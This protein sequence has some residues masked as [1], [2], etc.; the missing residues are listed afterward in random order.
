MIHLLIQLKGYVE[1]D[2][3]KRLLLQII[4]PMTEDLDQDLQEAVLI[5]AL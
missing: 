2:R 5:K 3:D 4:A 1:I